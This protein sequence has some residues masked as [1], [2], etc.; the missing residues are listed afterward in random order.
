MHWAFLF[1][2]SSLPT[3]INTVLETQLTLEFT[4]KKLICLLSLILSTNLWAAG[5]AN[6]LG[7][8]FGDPSGITFQHKLNERQFADFYFAYNWDDEVM[9]MGDYKFRLPGL[10]PSDVPVM[11]YVGIGVFMKI[12]DHKHDDDLALG[13]RIPLG[14]EWKIPEA[15]ITVFGELVP[16]LKVIKRTDG[17]FQ[18]GI[19]ARYFF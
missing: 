18:A 1:Q 8:V 17:D 10:F 15:P 7:I 13:V 2:D 5:G 9:L 14:V 11:P 6:G 12:E 4:V 16:A 19:G 3:T